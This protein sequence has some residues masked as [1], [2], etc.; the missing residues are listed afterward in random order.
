MISSAAQPTYLRSPR[1]FLGLL[2][3][4]TFACSPSPPDDEAAANEPEP[5]AEAPRPKESP[6]AIVLLVVD[7]LRADMLG[8]SDGLIRTPAFDALAED[9]VRFTQAFSHAPMTLPAH[10]ALFSSRPPFETGVLCNWQSVDGSLPLLPEWLAHQG[11]STHAVVSLGTLNP[12]K[13][14]VALDRGFATYNRDYWTMDTAPNVLAR[15]QQTLDE[16]PEQQPVFLFAHF[17]DPHAP[18][19]LHAGDVDT[20]EV[21]VDG[22]RVAEVSISNMTQWEQNFALE[23]G[24]HSVE[25]RAKVGFKVH[26]LRWAIGPKAQ[27]LDWEVGKKG[28]E[29]EQARVAIELGEAADTSLRFIVYDTQETF[30]EARD[31]YAGEV[32][33][34]DRYVGELVAQLRERG[35]Y[36]DALFV[37]TSDHGEALGERGWIGHVRDLYDEM[38]H[39]P[40]VI[41][42]PA[43]HAAR[44]RLAEVSGSLVPQQD[45]V[46]TVLEIAGLRPLPGALGTSLLSERTPL[47]VAETHRPVAPEDFI[48]L[49][50]EHFKMIFAPARGAYELY[51]LRADPG[52][53]DDVFDARRG[54]REEWVEQLRLIAQ[55]AAGAGVDGEL[56]DEGRDLLEALGYTA[57]R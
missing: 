48:C 5:R 9:G 49:R 35:L 33:W 3:L 12:L 18:Y 20:A 44:A 10:T 31:R 41:K 39:V 25:L 56:T 30:D 15:L 50:D 21:L 29:L 37:L 52:E 16:V 17:S 45:L 36:E 55:R 34:L 11:Y 27:R 51:D 22:E 8:R 4:V 24:Q 23:P 2:T 47:L 7:T 19:N 32:E 28:V 14:E 53:K 43:G 40:L 46:P 57:D 42:A 6:P 13:G 54:E 26:Q 1:Q 38:L